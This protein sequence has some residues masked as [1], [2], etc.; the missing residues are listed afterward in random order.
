[1]IVM[2]PIEEER[3]QRLADVLRDARRLVPPAAT[4]LGMVVRHPGRIGKPLSQEEV[5]EAVG[6]SRVWYAMLESG[7]PARPSVAVLQRVADVLG[8][9]EERRLCL[10]ALARPELSTSIFD[11]RHAAIIEATARMRR[12]AKRLWT[13]SNVEEALTIA[14][15]EVHTHFPDA[16]L[17]FFVHRV[18]PG[19][20]DHPFVVDRGMG[21]QN[22]HLYEELL[23]ALG[24]ERF[25]EVVLYPA[26]SEPGDVG[27]RE[28]F[29][30][31]SVGAE[32]EAAVARHKLQRWTLLHARVRSRSGVTG[33]IT[34]KHASDRDYSESDREVISAIAGLASLAI[35]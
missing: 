10:L 25:D 9:T 22:E 11:R 28:S 32:Y 27:T 8:L 12:S 23:H 30:G 4:S 24:R 2:E 29:A 35:P 5:A 18:T 7:R 31:T 16:A 15:E 13:A 1:M 17:T 21:T 26:L 34:V 14:A 19:H 33:G 20:W 3:P 6:V